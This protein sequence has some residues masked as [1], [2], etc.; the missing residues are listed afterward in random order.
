M[1]GA[2]IFRLAGWPAKPKQTIRAEQTIVRGKRVIIIA[3]SRA[4]SGLIE[5]LAV[6]TG[7]SEV[8]FVDEFVGD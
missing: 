5:L 3:N 8:C 4:N 6:G 7:N 2:C 1:A